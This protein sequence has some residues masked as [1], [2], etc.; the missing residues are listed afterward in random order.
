MSEGYMWCIVVGSLMYVVSLSAFYHYG[1]Y[2]GRYEQ[3]QD[4]R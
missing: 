3:S 1:Y 4:A 2:Q